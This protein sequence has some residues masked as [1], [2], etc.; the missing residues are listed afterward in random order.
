MGAPAVAFIVAPMFRKEPD[1]W[2]EV[3]LV[4]EFPVGSTVLVTFD[5]PSP[6][7]WA[8]VTGRAAAWLRRENEEEFVAFSVVCTHL[9]CNVRWLDQ[10][11]FFICPCHGA[12]F[13][14][15]GEVT[16]G[17]ARRPLVRHEVR[18]LGGQV[19]VRTL[20]LPV[21]GP[22]RLTTE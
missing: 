19:E 2:R 14:R 10:P 1:T 18:V 16:A 4:E 3:G 9:G 12:V 15:D 22:P 13:S 8:G 7:P 6:P 21:T 20:G 11:N 5:D 17:P